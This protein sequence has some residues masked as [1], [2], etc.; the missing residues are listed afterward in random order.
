MRDELRERAPVDLLVSEVGPTVVREPVQHTHRRPAL[1]HLSLAQWRTNA[2]LNNR[3]I[4]EQAPWRSSR[5]AFG[6][7]SQDGEV[8]KTPLLQKTCRD[9][10]APGRPSEWV[11]N[12]ETELRLRSFASL[13][14]NITRSRYL[15]PFQ[16]VAE[17]S[18]QQT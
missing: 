7:D 3:E 8:N 6:C 10:P 4:V 15:R 17:K 13:T 5:K 18:S 11:S 14:M 16:A 12:A 2:D 1:G 9:T